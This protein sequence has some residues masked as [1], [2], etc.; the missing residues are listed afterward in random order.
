MPDKFIIHGAT[1]DGDGTASNEAASDGAAGAWNN[2]NILFGTTPTYGTTPA[3]GDTV[4]IRSKTSAGADLSVTLSASTYMGINSLA[5]T[6]R[7]KWILDGGTKWS[8]IDGTFTIN[9]TAGYVINIRNYNSIIAENKDRWKFVCNYT[10][11]NNHVWWGESGAG[12]V[13]ENLT[14]DISQETYTQ[15]GVLNNV[16][17]KYRGCKFLAGSKWYGQFI[18]LTNYSFVEFVDCEFYIPTT[19]STYI[20]NA[21]QYGT[22]TKFIGGRIYGPGATTGMKIFGN[23]AG[24]NVVVSYG[25][26]YPKTC[27]LFNYATAYVANGWHFFMMGTDG[28]FGAEQHTSAALIDSRDDNYYPV[29]NATYPDS[30]ATGWSYKLYPNNRI[31]DGQAGCNLMMSKF[32]ANSTDQQDVTVEFLISED[33]TGPNKENIWIDVFYVDNT[34]G[35]LVMESSRD[36]AGGSLTTSSAAWN[37]TDADPAYGAVATDRYKLTVQTSGDVR[38][39]TMM[40]VRFNVA[41]DATAET[42]VYFVCPDFLVTPTV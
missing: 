24:T 10:A 37:G 35:L 42:H 34:S 11:A 4:Y 39:D 17:G 14:I 16:S 19:S 33:V 20:F 23:T 12:G 13:F 18:Y 28:G 26:Q 3:D 30:S 21:G 9:R 5:N 32:F 31:S 36:P 29:L 22:V 6:A 27:Q 8:G 41:I 40:Y 2:I 38:Q 25:F 15:G 1:Y 7:V